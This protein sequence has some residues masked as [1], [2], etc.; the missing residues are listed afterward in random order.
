MTLAVAAGMIP[1]RLQWFQ[2][3]PRNIFLD[4]LNGTDNVRLLN[5][6]WKGLSGRLRRGHRFV[7]KYVNE[8]E[9]RI[10]VPSPVSTVIGAYD[11]W[12]M[13][14]EPED[15]LRHALETI[16]SHRRELTLAGKSNL[17]AGEKGGKR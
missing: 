12:R 6:A 13:E 3:D 7:V 16:P 14:M 2:V 4:I 9:R 8:F 15:R 10:R 17:V 5:A 1:H 11:D